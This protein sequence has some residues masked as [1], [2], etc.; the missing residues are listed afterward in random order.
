MMPKIVIADPELTCKMPNSITAGTGMDAFAHCLEAYCS[1]HYHPM[2]H[3]IALEGMRLVTENLL[4]A[5]RENGNLTARTHMMTAAMMGATAFQKGLGAIHALSHPIGAIYDTHHGTTNAV[6]MAAV[7]KFNRER[8]EE[9]IATAAHYLKIDGGFE[10][11]LAYLDGLCEAIDIPKNLNMLGVKNIDRE[12][13]T[14]LA[15]KDPSCYGNPK[16]MNFDNV[17]A[18][19]ADC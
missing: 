10:G 19:L 6:I 8:I 5:Y 16:V 3:G 14:R 9:K 7:L 11:F 13:V 18:L 4:C 1:P 17:K 15:L 12:L 2:S